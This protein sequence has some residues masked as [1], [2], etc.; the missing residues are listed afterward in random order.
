MITDVSK[1]FDFEVPH[2]QNMAQNIFFWV[3]VELFDSVPN[4]I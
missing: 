2:R 1:L 3:Q 4:K